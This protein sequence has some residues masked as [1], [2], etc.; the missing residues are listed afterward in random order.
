MST[1]TKK[2][3][4]ELKSLDVA[5]VPSGTRG[6]K[7]SRTKVAKEFENSLGMRTLKAELEY[8]GRALSTPGN[9]ITDDA[10]IIRGRLDRLARGIEKDFRG[11]ILNNPVQWPKL[12]G[13]ASQVREYFLNPLQMRDDILNAVSFT[14]NTN[15]QT[16]EVK[17]SPH[18]IFS[19]RAH[20]SLNVQ[21]DRFAKENMKDMFSFEKK[22]YL[23]ELNDRKISYQEVV[24]RLNRVFNALASAT[25]G[26]YS[27]VTARGPA[28]LLTGR[29]MNSIK[30]GVRRIESNEQKSI[31]P[32]ANV[33]KNSVTFNYQIFLNTG[34]AV[35]YSKVLVEGGLL[36]TYRL[37][38]TRKS[39]R[40]DTEYSATF[41]IPIAFVPIL[42]MLDLGSNYEINIVQ[43]EATVQ[44][45]NPFYLDENSLKAIKNLEEDLG[46]KLSK[47]F[48]KFFEKELKDAQNGKH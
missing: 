33:D 11:H 21:A 43:H 47:D 34:L 27:T 48:Y 17:Y 26:A 40:S 46:V 39:M 16:G 5:K 29:F 1:K 15:K 6:V 25:S 20:Q 42:R 18:K 13:Y 31:L 9:A 30:L 38:I 4:I 44:G 37:T 28:L 45:R 10:R 22:R 2:F 12:L 14:S 36:T 3:T 23:K 35:P 7:T 8:V 24:E 19:E 41:P 32:L